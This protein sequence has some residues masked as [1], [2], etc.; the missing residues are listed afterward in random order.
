L[1]VTTGNRWSAGSSRKTLT[2][3]R[4]HSGNNR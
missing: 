2:Y 1:L 3:E 4:R